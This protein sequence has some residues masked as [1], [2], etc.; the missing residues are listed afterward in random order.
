[1]FCSHYFPAVG[2]HGRCH[3]WMVCCFIF[4]G[5]SA[6]M[7]MNLHKATPGKWLADINPHL[8]DVHHRLPNQNSCPYRHTPYSNIDPLLKDDVFTTENLRLS[9]KNSTQKKRRAAGNR[10]T[11]EGSGR[12]VSAKMRGTPTPPSSSSSPTPSQ[13]RPRAGGWVGEMVRGPK[14]SALYE[15]LPELVDFKLFGKTILV[16][17]K[18]FKVFLASQLGK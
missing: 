5:E 8:N 9:K 12:Y 15:S 4:Q 14:K 18:K 16:V 6:N 1:M 17:N 3:Y 13:R 10:K 7:D 11:S 2:F